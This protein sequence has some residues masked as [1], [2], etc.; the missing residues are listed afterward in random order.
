MEKGRHE[1]KAAG[2]PY[3]CGRGAYSVLIQALRM[4]RKYFEKRRMF[5]GVFDVYGT[6]AEALTFSF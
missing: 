1:R 6:F 4:G 5:C 3:A 2:R